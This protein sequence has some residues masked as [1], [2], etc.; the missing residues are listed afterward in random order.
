VYGGVDKTTGDSYEGAIMTPIFDVNRSVV[1]TPLT[2]IAYSMM[3]ELN[4][5]KDDSYSRVAQMVDVPEDFLRSDHLAKMIDGNDSERED[6]I[7]TIKHILM[8]QKSLEVMCDAVNN[9]AMFLEFSDM[10]VR[11]FEDHKDENITMSEILKDPN[12]I[13]PYFEFDDESRDYLIDSSMATKLIIEEIE[14]IDEKEFIDRNDS[15]FDYFTEMDLKVKAIDLVS[16]QYEVVLQER[17]E[18]INS[19]IDLIHDRI[20]LLGGTDELAKLTSSEESNIEFSEQLFSND[21]KDEFDR[22]I[23]VFDKLEIRGAEIEWIID[24]ANGM[25]API[26]RDSFKNQVEEH[27]E[28]E[29]SF[30]DIDSILFEIENISNMMPI[31]K[32]PLDI[33]D[34]FRV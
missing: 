6:S 28:R 31:P 9:D 4:L 32:E 30:E 5:S 19:S 21:Q 26:D 27:L 15:D 23:N 7:K 14:M 11:A 17:P 8:F 3:R 10:F 1:A 16:H 34:P 20:Y 29:F 25:E 24:L 13:A 18:D 2:T 12:Q 33:F 22:V